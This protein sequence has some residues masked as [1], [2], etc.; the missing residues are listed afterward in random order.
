MHFRR[1]DYLGYLA[2]QRDLCPGAEPSG[3][4]LRHGVG[5]TTTTSLPFGPHAASA[6]A[7]R[8]ATRLL[9]PWC[10]SCR[11]RCSR[12]MPVARR[13]WWP[14]CVPT[15]CSLPDR[16]STP[17]DFPATAPTACWAPRFDGEL[18]AAE[19]TGGTGRAFANPIGIN[20]Q[21]FAEEGRGA[22][23]MTRLGAA[24]GRQPGR[25]H[26]LAIGV[27]R[28]DYSKGL[29]K[30]LRGLWAG[31]SSAIPSTRPPDPLPADLPAASPRGGRRIPQA[32]RPEARPP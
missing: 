9:P 15:T 16:R 11:P 5:H 12:A 32:A 26:G 2:V 25:P 18:G 23:P 3:T 24:G 14:I 31:C 1:E 29:P 20:A 13:S 21:A 8:R 7:F 28:M 17:R 22:P 30:P 19:R 27:D 10:R 4:A 6:T